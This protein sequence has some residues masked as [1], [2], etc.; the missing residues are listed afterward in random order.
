MDALVMMIR[1]PAVVRVQ[2]MERRRC[3]AAAK[4]S[5]SSITGT[6]PFSAFVRR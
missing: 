5:V 1:T 4:L 2:A 6:G 3:S